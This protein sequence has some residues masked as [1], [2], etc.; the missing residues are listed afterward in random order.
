[1]YLLRTRPLPFVA[2][3]L[4]AL[5][6]PGCAPP[7]PTKPAAT[8]PTKGH[9]RPLFVESFDAPALLPDAAPWRPDDRPDDGPHSD[10]GTFF[11]ARG[12]S[13]PRD[14]YRATLPFG[15]RGWLTLESYSRS[16][17]TPL[18]ELAAVV[19]DPAGGANRVLRL[20]S[21]RHTDATV[22]RP[23][24]PLPRRY[25]VSLRVG[26]ADFGDGSPEGT[27]GYDGGE[28]AEPWSPRDATQQNG[29]YWLAI[30]DAPPRPH[31]NVWIHHH[32][33][34]VV[35]SDNHHPPWMEIF[36]GARF[37]PGGDFPVMLFALDG[38]GRTHPRNGKPFLSWS[39]G[40]V[41]PSGAIRAVDR[42]L[43]KRWYALT[44]ERNDRGFVVELAGEF[45]HGGQRAYRA[46]FPLDSYC[47]WH[48]NRPGERARGACADESPLPESGSPVPQWPVAGGWH[49]W[50]LFG[51]PHVNYYEGTA[52]YDD[53]RLEV[54][55]DGA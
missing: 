34:L 31:N 17:E 5:V 45:R 28:T 39:D 14:A 16:N 37:E 10:D 50:F 35:D 29:F 41:Q 18:R 4:A 20:R 36:D 26:Y 11:T 1:V 24:S 52:Y 40:R 9:W 54:W 38:A 8:A 55:H 27:N 48:Y 22:V 44:I 46:E 47:V 42:Y 21:P 49:D 3:A 30:T 19:D 53:L 15:Q 43:P 32:R 7:A 25:R 23:S 33:K 13:P 12:V 51:D 2:A 6:A